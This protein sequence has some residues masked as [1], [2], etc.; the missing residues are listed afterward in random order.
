MRLHTALHLLGAVVKAP[1]TGGRIGEDKAHLDFDVDMSR[2]IAP[3]IEAQLNE[4]TLRS[5]DTRVRWI[6]DAELEAHPELV[7]TMSVAPPRGEGRVRLLEIPGID[8]QACGGTH[9]A[10]TAEIGGPKVVRIRSEGKRNKRV[11]VELA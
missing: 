7:K 2:L 4:L 9:V 8:L 5:V 1:V 10:N 6:T 11:T 3:E